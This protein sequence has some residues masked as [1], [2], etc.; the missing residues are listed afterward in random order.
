V[1]REC[2]RENAGHTRLRKQLEDL[3]GLGS[4]LHMPPLVIQDATHILSE[5]GTCVTIDVAGG[6][7]AASLSCAVHE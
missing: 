7:M 4:A 6:F 3:E 2:D 1:G 5:V